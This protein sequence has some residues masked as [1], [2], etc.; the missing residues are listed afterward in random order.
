[1]RG[2]SPVALAALAASCALVACGGGAAASGGG[3]A[4][5]AEAGGG[6]PSAGGRSSGGEDAGGA[7]LD[8]EVRALLVEVLTPQ[9]CPRLL[10][11]Y[12][13]LPGEGE[14][15]GPA[16]GK[17]PSVGRWWIRRCDARVRGGRLDLSL[18]G[19]GWTWVERES[20]G[21]RVRQYLLVEMEA[22]LGVDLAVGYDRQK[23]LATLWMRPGE[24]VTASVRPVGSVTAQ[25]TG[26]FSS[27]IGGV[28][29]VFGTSADAMAREQ[30][31]EIGSAQLRER[32]GAGFTMTYA[33]DRRQTDFMVGALGRGE[34]PERPFDDDLAE[35]WLVNQRSRVWPGGLDVVGPLDLGAPSQRQPAATGGAG[36]TAPREPAPSD[37]AG[38]PRLPPPGPS[39][40]VLEIE[41]EEGEGASV[42]TVCADALE[43]Y[44]DQRFRAPEATPPTPG[45]AALIELARTRQLQRVPLPRAACPT[46][47]LVSVKQG[48]QLPVQLRY[49]VA[50]ESA[51]PAVASE[52]GGAGAAGGAAARPPRRVRIQVAGASVSAQNADGRAWDIVGG[53]ADVYVV[54]ASVPL[55]REIDRTPVAENTTSATW[56]RWL[57]GAFDP[58]QDLPLRFTLFD[59][60]L[61]TD[62]LIGSVDLD[63]SSVPAAAGVLAL[64]VRTTGAVPR[65]LGTLRLRLEPLP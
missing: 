37:G 27:V 35:P 55:G 33:L 26:F 45:G 21:F 29:P 10:G 2:A 41:L 50:P 14:A 46:L 24:G 40:M 63:A 25:A 36:A 8:E 38:G 30:V 31:A 34:T 52:A 56:D 57:P 12:I 17:L 49:R 64:P 39:N 54:T 5:A 43:R 7:P 62:E 32:L 22:S 53:E 59:K 23:R 48:S 42:R 18:G 3:A 13:G 44:F 58:G 60:D 19:P 15:R 51:A 9:L 11:S 20:S 1:V 28:L 65:Q 61:T 47:L 16:A 6:G 4:V